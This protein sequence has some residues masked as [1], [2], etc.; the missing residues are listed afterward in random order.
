VCLFALKSLKKGVLET[1]KL[2]EITRVKP[3]ELLTLHILI[4]NHLNPSSF[5]RLNMYFH[6]FVLKV[7]IESFYNIEP[8][9]DLLMK[10]CHGE[11]IKLFSNFCDNY[12]KKE[13]KKRKERRKKNASHCSLVPRVPHLFCDKGFKNT[14]GFAKSSNI[15]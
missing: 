6:C 3:V 4:F 8:S 2:G 11:K 5:A 14:S 12:C 15:I 9:V 1:Q 10:T 7:R 13:K